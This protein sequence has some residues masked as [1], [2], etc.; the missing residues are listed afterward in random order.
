MVAIGV[1]LSNV[2]LHGAAGAGVDGVAI[3]G[4]VALNLGDDFVQSMPL[5][6]LVLIL[7]DVSISELLS[8]TAVVVVELLTTSLTSVVILNVRSSVGSLGGADNL[9]TLLVAF[10]VSSVG[11]SSVTGSLQ[12]L[13]DL[14]ATDATGLGQLAVL[15][16]GSR[17]LLLFVLVLSQLQNLLVGQSA[18]TRADLNQG[19]LHG[20]GGGDAVE[21]NEIVVLCSKASIKCSSEASH[22]NTSSGIDGQNGGVVS[23]LAFQCSD[24]NSRNGG[25]LIGVAQ[26]QLNVLLVNLNGGGQHAQGLVPSEDGSSLVGQSDAVDR[27]IL[28]I[29]GLGDSNILVVQLQVE[30]ASNDFFLVIVLDLSS[31]LLQNHSAFLGFAGGQLAFLNAGN[32][33]GLIQLSLEQV[34]VEVQTSNGSGQVCGRTSQI[35]LNVFLVVLHSVLSLGSNLAAGTDTSG[36]GVAELGA[37][38]VDS[39]GVLLV[40]QSGDDLSLSIATDGAFLHL[41]AVQHAGSGRND[42]PGGVLVSVLSGQNL[43]AGGALN[44]GVQAIQAIDQLLVRSL[45]SQLSNGGLN[46]LAVLLFEDLATLTAD[47]VLVH[48]SVVALDIL[49]S[50]SLDLQQVLLVVLMGVDDI[51][52]LGSGTLQTLVLVG[53]DAL[54]DSSGNLL[55]LT[56]VV[57]L[58]NVSSLVL[59]LL[60]VGAVSTSSGTG[61][62]LGAVEF[63]SSP[64]AELTNGN[65]LFADSGDVLC[66]LQVATDRALFAALV[67]LHAAV[68]GLGLSGYVIMLTSSFSPSAD[69]SSVALVTLIGSETLCSTSR[70]GHLLDAVISAVFQAVGLGACFSCEHGGGQQRNNHQH[71]Q[72]H[73][74]NLLSHS[75]FPSLF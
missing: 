69:E 28:I 20:A 10:A 50:G 38:S 62:G 34:H 24:G 40:A 11:L 7:E 3:L 53:T 67:T 75:F 16:T 68:S 42:I 33:Q 58:C 56:E 36:E 1:V 74:K 49:S 17:F 32:E 52:G 59:V 18:A 25:L 45:L 55:P 47:V 8:Q 23:G 22:V 39:E 71:S 51:H 26:E 70:C 63:D 2:N 12:S 5:S 41:E 57:S 15:Q 29:L 13:L 14:V 37:G 54:N 31:N 21:V 73:C 64:L 46:E 61:V 35:K 6:S 72:E 48:L 65:T 43:L 44:T 19:A 30:L 27:L 66:A 60:G 9:V 4:A